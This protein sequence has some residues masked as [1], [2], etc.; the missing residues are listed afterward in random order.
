MNSSNKYKIIALFGKAGSGKDTIQ[1]WMVNHFPDLH[2]IVSCTTRPP[3]D[4]EENDVDYHFLS[5]ED[6]TKQV[7]DGTMLEATDF[8][9]W[10]YGTPLS[11]LD[12]DRINIGVFNIA[13]I[14]ALLEDSRLEV[15][16]VIIYA[17]DKTRL[18]RQLM[19]EE[20][21]DCTEICRR[22]QTDNSD[23]LKVDFE[24]FFV[25]QNYD[26]EDPLVLW[27]ENLSTACCLLKKI[28]SCT[29]DD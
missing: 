13:G 4:Y 11:S 18:I 28:D 23:F 14:Q 15:Y 10:F 17:P 5:I 9:G 2:G 21:P 12:I 22:F 8:R 6:F 24:P 1:K 16:P 7:L 19:R 26:E 29:K 3:R 27:Q 20:Q 25:W